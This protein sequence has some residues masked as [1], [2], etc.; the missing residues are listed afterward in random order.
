MD[1]IFRMEEL[2]I[3]VYEEAVS[4]ERTHRKEKYLGRATCCDFLICL[5]GGDAKSGI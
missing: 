5:A 4:E 1:D 2:K 3:L